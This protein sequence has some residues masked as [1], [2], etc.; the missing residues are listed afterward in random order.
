MIKNPSEYSREN[1]TK[2]DL[3]SLFYMYLKNWN[4]NDLKN[5][6]GYNNNEIMKLIMMILIK[7]IN[8]NIDKNDTD[9]MNKE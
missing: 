5:N 2:R 9:S 8:D 3:C 4:G 6:E 1:S 7:N